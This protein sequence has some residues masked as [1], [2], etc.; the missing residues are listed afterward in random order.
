MHNTHIYLHAYIQFHVYIRVSKARCTYSI[1]LHIVL[2]ATCAKAAEARDAVQHL[3]MWELASH[4]NEQNAK[5]GKGQSQHRSQEGPHETLAKFETTKWAWCCV[6]IL[7][8]KYDG[9]RSMMRKK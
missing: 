2:S 9:R 1:H 6:Y 5:N 3:R 8:R 4:H 7:I